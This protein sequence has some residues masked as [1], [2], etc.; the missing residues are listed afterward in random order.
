[1]LAIYEDTNE[2]R[3]LCNCCANQRGITRQ[4]IDVADRDAEC[5]DCGVNDF[6]MRLQNL[7]AEAVEA[8]FEWF[9]SDGKIVIQKPL[10]PAETRPALAR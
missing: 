5:M 8:G 10:M 4:R 9:A 1:M 2:N 7:L 3:V 6:E